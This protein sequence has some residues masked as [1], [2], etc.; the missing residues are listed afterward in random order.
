MSVY[1][2]L[3]DINFASGGSILLPQGTPKKYPV[4]YL[5]HGLGGFE[6]WAD[7]NKANI[8]EKMETLVAKQGVT[9]CVVVMPAIQRC[10]GI[11]NDE[12][13]DLKALKEKQSVFFAYDIEGLVNYINSQYGSWVDTE[14]KSRAIAGFSMGATA[15]IYHAVK[16][17]GLFYHLGAVSV[18]SITGSLKEDAFKFYQSENS[19][20]YIGYSKDEGKAFSQADKY[21]IYSFKK[22]GNTVTSN[23]IEG[24]TH[25][26][27]TFNPLLDDFICKVYGKDSIKQ[28]RRK[29]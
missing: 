17:K 27:A 6:E 12:V 29:K 23:E 26:F 3:Q 4:L 8:K 18:A 7:S 28:I 24:T 1:Q 16:H 14:E 22:N 5:L 25:C 15:S 20:L 13:M 21:C 11:R 19:I 9:P 2:N 10:S